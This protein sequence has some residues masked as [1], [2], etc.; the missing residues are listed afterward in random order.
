MT[1]RF[2]DVLDP[3]IQSAQF[4][5]RL[6][7]L[8]RRC[9]FCQE[10]K[11]DGGIIG[12]QSHEEHHRHCSKIHRHAPLKPNSETFDAEDTM[13]VGTKNGKKDSDDDILMQ[14]SR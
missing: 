2:E 5:N 12:P 8:N 6:K 11:F 4:C 1:C 9:K 14:M 10:V 13:M 7:I 3:E